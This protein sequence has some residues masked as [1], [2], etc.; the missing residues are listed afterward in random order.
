M[1]KILTLMMMVALASCGAPQ[2]PISE[3]MDGDP[4]PSLAVVEGGGEEPA[5]PVALS[6]LEDIGRPG[7]RTIIDRVVILEGGLYQIQDWNAKLQADLL[8]LDLDIRAKLQEV[9]DQ[10]AV[11]EA[12]LEQLEQ[13]LGGG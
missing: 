3:G 4:T 12:K 13:K 6:A 10:L 7:E 2:A 8:F 1:S 5:D 9:K 11:L